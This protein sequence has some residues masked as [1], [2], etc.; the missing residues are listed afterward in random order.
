[1]LS[2]TFMQ[3]ALLIS[4][5]IAILCPCIGIFLVLKRYSMI[6]DTLAH[7][8]LAGVTLGLF[9]NK[10]PIISAF[11]FTSF[12]GLAIEFLRQYFRRYTDLILAIILSM[13][14]GIA[15]TLITSGVLHAN[16]NM[17]LFGSM[18]TVSKTDLI[19]TALLSIIAVATLITF[20]HQLLYL[21][22]D[23]TAAKVVNVKV[24]TINYIFAILVAAAISVSIRSVGILV[25]SSMV[26]LPVAS[27]LQLNKGFRA[28]L[29]ASIAYSFL[30]I[31]SGLI[32]SYYA[33]AAPG[34]IT[35]LIATGTLLL[36]I[37]IKQI[38]KKL[39][40]Y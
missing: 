4:I 9:F 18:L 8:S 39:F 12:G 37:V 31:L 1:M 10:S 27:A 36:T 20:Y 13:S 32:I 19:V 16:A 29:F 34:G 22:Y 40:T 3:N 11:L 21:A 38:Q 17:Y 15:I 25:I 14:V 24:K 26:A 28:T 5:C 7:A 2:Y 30:D 35:A 33:G 6:G 23:E